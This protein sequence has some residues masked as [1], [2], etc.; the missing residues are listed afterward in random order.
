MLLPGA[1]RRLVRS[2]LIGGV[3]ASLVAV[4][5]TSRP[6][7]A[8]LVVEHDRCLVPDNV[9][10]A[11]AGYSWTA[12]VWRPNGTPPYLA[13]EGI[14]TEFKVLRQAS[15]APLTELVVVQ[16]PAPEWED[17][18]PWKLI[19]G[20]TYYLLSVNAMDVYPPGH[21]AVFLA[22]YIPDVSALPDDETFRSAWLDLCR[23]RIVEAAARPPSKH[24]RPPLPGGPSR[25]DIRLLVPGAYPR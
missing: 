4:G 8:S 14:K 7:P 2:L 15:G 24:W 11:E 10:I 5:F 12:D 20:A 23:H 19:R 21:D 18:K 1:R 16:V 13:R 17:V 3:A 25:D 6:S 9:V 22:F